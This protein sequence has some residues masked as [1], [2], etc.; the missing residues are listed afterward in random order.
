MS[1]SQQN[2]KKINETL[3]SPTLIIGLVTLFGYLL[4]Y[5]SIIGYY[6]Y[7]N[8]PIDLIG[9]NILRFFSFGKG[10]LLIFIILIL[11]LIFAL[12]FARLFSFPKALERFTL[13]II[14]LI[15]SGILLF[16]VA[17]K[18]ISMNLIKGVTLYISGGIIILEAITFIYLFL[19]DPLTW[20]K[21]ATQK[22]R[23]AII[24]EYIWNNE[25]F[26][27]IINISIIFSTLIF[28]INVSMIT[29]D[30]GHITASNQT[31]FYV[32]QSDNNPRQIIFFLTEDKVACMYYGKYSHIIDTTVSILD[33][34][35][36]D[37]FR[38]IN[39]ET[40]ELVP[41]DLFDIHNMN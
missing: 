17:R 1:E 6:E 16:Y 22:E 40:G 14:I 11:I 20:K 13:A 12:T 39:T 15:A 10:I 38:I 30:F 18:I 28:I 5:L 4:Y 29:K 19:I 41:G 26:K 2:E 9:F 32:V 7:F 36:I 31:E 37:E 21:N 24:K 34:N 27:K 23:I 8:I 33:I 25:G 35:E 3:L